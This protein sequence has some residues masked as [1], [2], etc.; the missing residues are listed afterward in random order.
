M[1]TDSQLGHLVPV[2]N[3]TNGSDDPG[4]DI[5]RWS[6]PLH[7]VDGQRISAEQVGKLKNHRWERNWYAAN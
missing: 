2:S 3:E 6:F 1:A 7:G 5:C 4:A